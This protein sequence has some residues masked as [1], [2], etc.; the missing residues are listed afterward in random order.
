MAGVVG[1]SGIEDF[2][3]ILGDE[4]RKII[5]GEKF[6][7]G[8]IGWLFRPIA[9]LVG[10]DQFYVASPPQGSITLETSDGGEVVR[11]LTEAVFI[12]MSDRCIKDVWWIESFERRSTRFGQ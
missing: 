2:H 11:F 8:L 6:R 5:A 1:A 3:R 4:F 12:K 7:L 10:D 9:A